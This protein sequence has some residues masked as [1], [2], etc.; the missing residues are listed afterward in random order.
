MYSIL[1]KRRQYLSVTNHRNLCKFKTVW[2]SCGIKEKPSP[3]SS[4]GVGFIASKKVGGAVKRNTAKRRLR[5]AVRLVFKKNSD[6]LTTNKSLDFVF[7]ALPRTVDCTF[8][9]LTHEVFEGMVKCMKFLQK[10]QDRL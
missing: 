5:E 6:V 1:K 10:K 8:E 7:I 9:D 4:L 2:T 3:E